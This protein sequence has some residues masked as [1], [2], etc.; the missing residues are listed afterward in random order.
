[1]LDSI[2]EKSDF[3]NKNLEILCSWNGEIEDLKNKEPK[4]TT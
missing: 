3:K 2:N 1:M 4:I